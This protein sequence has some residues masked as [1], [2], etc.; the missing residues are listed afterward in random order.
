MEDNCV[1]IGF[2]PAPT[3]DKGSTLSETICNQMKQVRSL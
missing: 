1:K 2:V 3:P